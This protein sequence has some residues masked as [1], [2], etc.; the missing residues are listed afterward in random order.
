MS[1]AEPPRPS[2][3]GVTAPAD[4][5][6]PA[7]RD[8]G[9]GPCLQRLDDAL[10]AAA[11]L[12]IPADEARTIAR[13]VAER[14][15][16]PAETYVLALVGGTG[17]GKSS[18][19]NALAGSSVSDASVR[20][21]TT[22]QPLAWVPK[23]SRPGLAGL[24]DWL[25]VPKD[26][27][28]DHRGDALG[29][30]AIL[31][32]PDL[33][34]IESAHRERVEAILPRVDAV[35]WVTDP[36]KYHDAILHDDFLADWLPRLDRQVVVL[37]KTDRL[38]ADDAERVRRDLER[39]LTRIAGR[40][41]RA[42]P[43]QVLLTSTRSTDPPGIEPLRDWLAAAIEAKR[44]VR[45]HLVTAIGAT[46]AALARA[47]G[48]DPTTGAK[49]LVAGEARRLTSDRVTAELLRVVDLP[50]AERQAVAA[51]RARA[52]ARGAGPLGA[53]TSR[54]Y[55]WSGRQGRVA[56]PGAFLARWRERGS[57]APALEVL[58]GAVDVPLHEA[59]AAMR[60]TLAS[61]V[62]PAALSTN[63]A[64]SVD[65]AIAARAATA[66]SSRIWTVIGL[67]Q[68]LAT[69]AL[70]FSAVWVALWIF[71][72]FPVDAVVL[73]GLGQ[74]PIP[75]IALVASLL[76][77]YLIARLLG[78]H[79]GWVGRRWARGLAREVRDSVGREVETSAFAA[80]DR[81]EAGRR[82]LWNAARG[83]GEDCA[84]GRR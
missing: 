38:S 73:P 77:G 76:A 71:V 20:R 61:S 47:A 12:G 63:L 3:T 32:L 42:K 33:D 40:A 28:R 2:A 30:V 25:G 10:A 44:V 23:S 54:I 79:A 50:A 80:L 14:L 69:M 55:R 56:D 13:D 67:L 59:P 81:V 34:S 66:P 21:P 64:R 43:V 18:L 29:D 8:Q 9:V 51:T 11:T 58:R 31:D 46:I 6:R 37:N 35:V 5:A 70:I 78:A 53:I 48:V 17:V 39:D 57:L 62:E 82:A 19:L 7:T 49:P 52:R 68:T 24:L 84:P 72:K 60:G 45:A 36:E 41:G 4:R 1:V 22:A 27:V 65:R 16:F 74:L 83:A 15:G 26:Q 75:F